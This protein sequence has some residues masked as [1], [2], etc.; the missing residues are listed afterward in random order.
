MATTKHECGG[1]SSVMY[2][3]AQHELEKQG[4][5]FHALEGELVKKFIL[6]DE[7][8][9]AA[10]RKRRPAVIPPIRKHCP[11]CGDE[12]TI[13]PPPDVVVGTEFRKAL[14]V[15]VCARCDK[16]PALLRPCVYEPDAF[17]DPPAFTRKAA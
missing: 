2:G 16:N 3:Y 8:E 1:C 4:W 13:T 5:V 7:C 15:V 11:D 10:A 9:K 12:H 17:D 6:C 14:P